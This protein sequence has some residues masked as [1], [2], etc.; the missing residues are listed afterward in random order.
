MAEIQL[1][2]QDSAKYKAWDKKLDP[3]TG[4]EKSSELY[5]KVV[6]EGIDSP[7][8]NKEFLKTGKEKFEL[9]SDVIRYDIHDSGKIDK[10]VREHATKVRYN[11]F[12]GKTKHRIGRVTFVEG[13]WIFKDYI[14]TK[15]KLQMLDIRDLKSYSNGNVKFNFLTINVSLKHSRFYID[16]DAYAALIAAMIEESIEDLGYNGFSS[17]NGGS[18]A[19]SSHWNDM[20]GDLRYLSTNKNGEVTYLQHTHFDYERQ[21]R[22][23]NALY[24]FGFSKYYSSI[25]RKTMM[26]YSENFN[27]QKIEKILNPKSKKMEEKVIISK[28][29]S[30]LP[31]TEHYSTEKA[32]HYHHLH[33]QGFD[34]SYINEIK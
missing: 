30:L 32:K 3:D 23:N 5:L 7:A 33:V 1:Q 28:T 9:F 16:I 25:R 12:E 14:Y 22:F 11:Y 10:Y 29:S 20:T 6:V 4:D 19:S 21:I 31:H 8:T 2:K 13:K 24:K 17:K 27:R 26:M 34:P 15:K 18:G